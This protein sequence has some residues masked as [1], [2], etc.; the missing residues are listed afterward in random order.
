[1]TFPDVQNWPDDR[2][3]GLDEVGITGVRYPVIVEDMT[4][5]VTGR[6]RAGP[7]IA[8][9]TVTAASDESIHD[10]DAFARLSWPPQ[11]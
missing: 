5:G 9:F 3:I 7:R 1:M 2:G 4:R 8:R 6:L 10:H 11:E